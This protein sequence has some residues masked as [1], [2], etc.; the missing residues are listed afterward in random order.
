[1][2]HP[3]SRSVSTRLRFAMGVPIVK[4]FK[5]VWR[6]S[7]TWKAVSSTMNSVARS[8]RQNCVTLA[9]SS[10]DSDTPTMLAS[11]LNAAARGWS[12]GSSTVATSCNCCFQ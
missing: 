8:R 1:M 4:R 10:L 2:K 7:A 12:V 5:P 11:W 6:E 9:V 3:I